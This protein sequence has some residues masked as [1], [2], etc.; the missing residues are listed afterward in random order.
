MES[1]KKFNIP[2]G[3]QGQGKA[4]GKLKGIKVMLHPVADRNVRPPVGDYWLECVSKLGFIVRVIGSELR[5]ANEK[6]S[7]GALGA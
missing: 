2:S 4:H 6:P 1:Y 5:W 3:A 7:A